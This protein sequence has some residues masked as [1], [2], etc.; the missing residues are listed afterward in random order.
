IVRLRGERVAGRELLQT[1]DTSVMVRPSH[2]QRL[3]ISQFNLYIAD[4]T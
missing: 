1:A 3:W 2:Y 4:S